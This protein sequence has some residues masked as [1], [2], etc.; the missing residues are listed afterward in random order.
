MPFETVFEVLGLERFALIQD[1]ILARGRAA[2]FDIERISGDLVDARQRL[3]KLRDDRGPCA[4]ETGVAKEWTGVRIALHAGHDDEGIARRDVANPVDGWSCGAL[5]AR[6]VDR[7]E[8]TMRD[9]GVSAAGGCRADDKRERRA[10]VLN[11]DGPR[12]VHRAAGER[13]RRYEDA[14]ILAEDCAQRGKW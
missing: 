14:D 2:E 5:C 3:G 10:I 13:R 8:L 11:I 9:V 1:R 4:F 7:L 6:G 12:G